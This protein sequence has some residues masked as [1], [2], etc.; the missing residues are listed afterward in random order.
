MSRVSVIIP[1][2]DRAH[3]IRRVLDSVYSQTRLPDEVIV[4]DDG[5]KDDTCNII[6]SHYPDVVLLSQENQGVSSARNKGIETAKFDWIALLD[7]DDAWQPEKIEYQMKSLENQSEFLFCHTN[8]IWIRNGVHV[9][10]L[11]KHAKRGGDI[12]LHCLPL[13]VI[14][15]SSV[16][17]NRTI[18]DSV[19]LFDTNL[20]VCEDYDLWLRICSRFPVLYLN[21]KLVTKYGGHDDQLSRKYWGMDRF[22][23][24]ALENIISE[25]SLSA[26]ER[27]EAVKMMLEKIN[28]YLHGAYK[29]NNKKHVAH[30][31]RLLKFYSKPENKQTVSIR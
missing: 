11:K 10:P 21:E 3:L 16:I 30:Y 29:H 4:V 26:Y 1:T 31:E 8:E 20:P 19:G 14:S 18:L 23:I 13:C 6:K 28:I 15:P 5:S 2:R 24:M 27:D 9:N 12:F 17:M 25:T 22:R 7:S